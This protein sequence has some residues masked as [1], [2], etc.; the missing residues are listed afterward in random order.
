MVLNSCQRHRQLQ[1][2]PLAVVVVMESSSRHRDPSG[3]RDRRTR[4]EP[5]RREDCSTAQS[6]Q[7]NGVPSEYFA[8]NAFT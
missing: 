5:R 7:K 2:C 8:R 1:S 4:R 6:C 3:E